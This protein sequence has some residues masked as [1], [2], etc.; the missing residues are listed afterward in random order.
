MMNTTS[1]GFSSGSHG[2]HNGTIS[3]GQQAQPQQQRHEEVQEQA[4][5]PASRNGTRDVSKSHEITSSSQM[6]S[7]ESSQMSRQSSSQDSSRQ[8]SPSS[9]GL[10]R[11]NIQVEKNGQNRDF[12]TTSVRPS[13][14]VNAALTKD[15]K[16]SSLVAGTAD[17]KNA[18]DKTEA[19]DLVTNNNAG[20]NCEVNFNSSEIGKEPT[21]SKYEHAAQEKQNELQ[22][23]KIRHHIYK[24]SLISSRKHKRM[25]ATTSS[26]TTQNTDSLEGVMGH[27]EVEVEASKVT[28]PQGCDGNNNGN[29]EGHTGANAGSNDINV[30][31]TAGDAN[32]EA[33]GNNNS[34]NASN[35]NSNNNIA[36]DTKSDTSNSS[37]FF[38]TSSDEYNM[39]TD[40]FSSGYEGG[41]SGSH[42][43]SGISSDS[44]SG[45]SR[46]RGRSLLSSL[47]RRYHH[48]ESG[49]SGSDDGYNCNLGYHRSMDD[50][51]NDSNKKKKM[52]LSDSPTNSSSS[53]SSSD[54][55]MEVYNMNI[56]EN[57]R[58]D[59]VSAPNDD[60]G[61][62]NDEGTEI[63]KSQGN[64]SSSMLISTSAATT[65]SETMSNSNSNTSS[66]I[67]HH[68]SD[69]NKIISTSTS[70]KA[71]SGNVSGSGTSSSGDGRTSGSG[72]VSGTG[73]GSGTTGESNESGGNNAQKT[74]NTS[75]SATSTKDNIKNASVSNENNAM[76]NNASSSPSQSIQRELK[77]DPY[78]YYLDHSQ[79]KE[80]DPMVPLVRPLH[81][82]SFVIK[83]CSCN[84]KVV[85]CSGSIH[86]STCFNHFL[87]IHANPEISFQFSFSYT[88]YS[89]EMTSKA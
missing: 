44:N 25:R 7:Q 71:E 11:G 21:A 40:R 29:V 36:D 58:E 37:N 72:N 42:G 70:A 35:A 1:G 63:K 68:K 88:P 32:M 5:P 59:V 84:R 69:D 18:I 6:S 19:S 51:G 79:E 16:L 82:P 4:H 43:D 14:T 33:S 61:K 20:R 60:T 26:L 89:C 45:S 39:D 2:G 77:P 34:N 67:T 15:A 49:S 13:S 76:K 27:Q 12:H 31:S 9:D 78:F 74:A 3:N 73:S 56:I 41:N 47:N 53:T 66:A 80:E 65:T 85:S 38:S 86:K 62:I 52:K 55:N 24:S 23:P 48:G 28:N 87:R 83:V 81:S 17:V 50:S 57:N 64:R 8:A 30:T 75:S 10:G 22:G 46:N 54:E